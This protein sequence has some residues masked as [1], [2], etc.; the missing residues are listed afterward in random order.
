MIGALAPGLFEVLR[1]DY[2][3]DDAMVLSCYRAAQKR[4]SVAIRFRC[5]STTTLEQ[6][7]NSRRRN[8]R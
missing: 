7:Y 4:S 2:S 6:S 8:A 5:P 1:P 3:H